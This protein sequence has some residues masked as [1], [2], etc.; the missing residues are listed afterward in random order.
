MFDQSVRVERTMIPLMDTEWYITVAFF[1]I[2]TLIVLTVTA[3][4]LAAIR[5]THFPPV[6]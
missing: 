6:K 5:W 4:I 2:V 1:I 3:K